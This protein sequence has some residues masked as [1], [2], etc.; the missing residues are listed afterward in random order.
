MKKFLIVCLVILSITGCGY[1]KKQ[2]KIINPPK[3]ETIEKNDFVSYNG[4][5]RIND[6]NIVN[7]YGE[8]IQLKGISSHGIQW[9]G[10]YINEENLKT[11]KNDW[12]VNV[13]RIA[14]YT[15]EGGYLT[16]SSIEDKVN[17]YVEMII[18]QDMYVIIDWHIL[19]DN[20]PMANIDKSKQFFERM[21]K[22]YKNVPNVIFEICNEPNGNVTWKD[23]I[24]P[25]AEEIIKIIRK[26]TTNII[27]VGTST[28]S[29]DVDIAADD[30]L[31]YS[32][33]AYACHF[34]AGTHTSWLRDKIDYALNKK[35]AIFV[36]EWGTSSA[37]GNGGVFL[38]ESKRWLDYLNSKKISWINWS[39]SDKQESSAI[40]KPGSTNIS[41][42]NL[43]ESGKFI[44]EQIKKEV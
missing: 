1:N 9:Y 7:Q 31:N 42:V 16:D 23:N 36:T 2:E 17:K 18:K 43:S 22:K 27:V 33:I 35:I 37:D 34:Y 12:G 11:L 14:M 20:D 4:L 3:K 5:L 13:F 38:D 24:K 21:A 19:K 40:L 28:W 30:P 32:N 10:D 29:Q 8:I 26:Y 44:K 39:L 6:T 15:D 41:D 25:Y